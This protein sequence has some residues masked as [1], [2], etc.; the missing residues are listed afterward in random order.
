MRDSAF[1]REQRD[2]LYAPHVAPINTLVDG[3]GRQADGWLPHVAPVHGGVQAR[4]LWVLRDP[5]PA[6]AD[7]DRDAAGFLCVENDDPTAQRLCDLLARAEIDVADTVPW[8]A[9]HWYINKA[10]SVG[11]LRAGVEPLR[12]LLGLLPRLEVVLLL[13]QH[14]QRSWSLLTKTRPDVGARLTVL[15]SRHPSRQAF[16]GSATERKQWQEEQA[17]VF[18]QGG[19]V[20]RGAGGPAMVHC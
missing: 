7:P 18:E 10:P 6:V 8:N 3:L 5:G 14:A 16:I 11:Q 2:G 12:R 9:Y 20:I 13:G 1:R 19:K 4:L 17:L 15:Q